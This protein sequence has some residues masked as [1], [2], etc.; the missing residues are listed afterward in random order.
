MRTLTDSGAMPLYLSQAATPS[1]AQFER[2][3]DMLKNLI[4]F[5]NAIFEAVEWPDG[6]ELD[7]GEFEEIAVKYGLLLPEIRHEPCSEFC[8]C[9]EVCNEEDWKRGVTC[10][11][12]AEW[13]S[14]DLESFGL[15]LDGADS[16][17]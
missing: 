5:A 1:A 11:R 17:I 16:G 15:T 6:L 4:G 3:K 12:K 14:V 9:T 2:I 7:A 8:P 13:L 10:N